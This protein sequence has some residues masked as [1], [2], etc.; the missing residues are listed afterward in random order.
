MVKIS[1]LLSA[2][3]GVNTN[4]QQEYLYIHRHEAVLPDYAS[5]ACVLDNQN[6]LIVPTMQTE[7]QTLVCLKKKRCLLQSLTLKAPNEDINI[8]RG[9]H[10]FRKMIKSWG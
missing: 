9:N 3:Q 2:I 6:A 8:K 7:Y 10:N 1:L 5:M 4:F